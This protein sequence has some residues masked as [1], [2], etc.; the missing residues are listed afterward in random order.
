MTELSKK[1]T[2]TETIRNPQSEYY[3]KYKQSIAETSTPQ[4]D[5]KRVSHSSSRYQD[6]VGS[7][8]VPMSPLTATQII[9]QETN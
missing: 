5:L 8:E 4:I 2:P 1:H 9:K 7:S 6:L 3:P